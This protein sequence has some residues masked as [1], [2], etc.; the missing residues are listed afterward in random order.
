MAEGDFE[1]F[2]HLDVTTLLSKLSIKPIPY[3]WL[4]KYDP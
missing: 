4:E 1:N 3:S 2:D